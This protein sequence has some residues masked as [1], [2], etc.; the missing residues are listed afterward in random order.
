MGNIYHRVERARN[1]A[2]GDWQRSDKT[3]PPAGTLDG[4]FW[5]RVWTTEMFVS[6][7]VVQLSR[8]LRDGRLGKLKR[9]QDIFRRRNAALRPPGEN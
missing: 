7:L 6:M 5:R 2:V 4:F 1:K 8:H 9:P 3:K